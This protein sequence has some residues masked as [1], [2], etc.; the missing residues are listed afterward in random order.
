VPEIP[1]WVVLGLVS[2]VC[3]ALVAIFGKAGLEDVSPVAATTARAIIMAGITSIAA[4]A[5]GGAHELGA[6]DRR[7]WLFIALAG[8]AGAASWLAYFAA[9]KLGQASA[10][11]AL[12][13]LSVVFIV[14]LAALFLGESLT[15]AKVAGAALM[16]AGAVLVAR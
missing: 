6:I 3:A 1:S 8:V 16:V 12:D 7:G 14:I 15:V 10:I 4:F 5:S 11:G 2:A 13:R 9:L